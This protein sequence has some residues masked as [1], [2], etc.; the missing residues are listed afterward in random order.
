MNKKPTATITRYKTNRGICDIES[1]EWVK[2][3]KTRCISN[4]FLI[5]VENNVET[6]SDR[7]IANKVK[8]KMYIDA[9]TIMIFISDWSVQMT[10][11]DFFRMFVVIVCI[12]QSD[13]H[14]IYI[15]FS[16]SFSFKYANDFQDIRANDHYITKGT[17]NVAWSPLNIVLSPFSFIPELV[18]SLLSIKESRTSIC[19]DQR[20]CRKEI[21]Q[22]W[23]LTMDHVLFF[24]IFLFSS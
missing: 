1:G 13:G 24:S 23:V 4:M 8:R 9:I 20:T 18:L 15:Y 2:Q 21:F 17:Y 12:G 6:F 3:A 5:Y 11:F 16:P 7:K 22:R 14:A 10:S 19:M